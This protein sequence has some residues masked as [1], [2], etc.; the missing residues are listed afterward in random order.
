MT[1]EIDG[2]TITIE[3]VRAPGAA[4]A[5]ASYFQLTQVDADIILDVGTIDDQQLVTSLRDRGLAALPLSS[6]YLGAGRRKGLL[7][8]FGC[9][10]PQQLFDATRALSESLRDP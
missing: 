6:S 10:T 8:G 9:A 4:I 3:G 7:L 1:S 5:H 2:K